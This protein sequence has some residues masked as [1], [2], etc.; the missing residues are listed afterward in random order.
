MRKKCN[1][2]V[3][4]AYINF[5]V[6]SVIMDLILSL[7]DYGFHFVCI[8]LQSHALDARNLYKELQY[9]NIIYFGIHILNVSTVSSLFGE[10]QKTMKMFI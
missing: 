3:T 9:N 10:V 4:V 1:C 2:V 7:R 8:V 5:S 6:P